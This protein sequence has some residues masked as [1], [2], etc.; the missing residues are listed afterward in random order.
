M[1]FRYN[2]SF[3]IP[4]W[5]G[6]LT[7]EDTTMRKIAITVAP[8]GIGTL[9]G[10]NNPLTPEAIAS[11]AIACFQAG[12]AQIHLHVRNAYG[13]PTSDLTVFDRSVQAI[14]TSTDLII[15]GST[16]GL[17]S[18]SREDRCVSLDQ[19]GVEVASLN[20]GCVNF[21]EM[22]YLNSL[23]DIRFWASR[24]K[25]NKI[26]PELEIF[27]PGMMYNAFALVKEGVLPQNN[28]YSFSLGIGPLPANVH[29]LM[30]LSSL[31]PEGS[32]W[33]CIHTGM[34]DFTMLATAIGMGASYI[35]VGF[36]DSIAYAPGHIAKSN[37]E[38]VARAADL[39]RAMGC[40]VATPTQVRA[41]LHGT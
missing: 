1:R 33:G 26:L 23:A 15:Q 14:R 32:V 30:M 16:G 13:Q 38:L 39:I 7:S 41:M 6:D 10:V 11:E 9:Q 8:A 4:G 40:E 37:A 17:S 22:L 2:K 34:E 19:P 5:K 3:Y 27:E 29:S 25:E 36:E 20:M 18:L 28:V 21:G 12:A 35:R 31:V 24:M